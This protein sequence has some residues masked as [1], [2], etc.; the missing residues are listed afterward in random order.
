[1]HGP[2]GG[3]EIIIIRKGRSWG[4]SETFVKKNFMSLG[5]SAEEILKE[6]NTAIQQDRQRLKEAKKQQKNAES[7]ARKKEKATQEMKDLR[8]R[9]ERAKARIDQLLSNVENESELRELQQRVRNYRKDYENLKTVVAALEKQR[10]QKES[11]IQREQSQAAKLRASLAAKESK[12]NTVEVRLNN[13]K[14]LDELKEQEAELQRQNEE[15]EAV[16]QDNDA[17]PSNRK[18]AR[19]TV[20]G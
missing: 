19:E 4:I 5:K 17:S 8:I 18:A 9:T 3:K 13:T 16:V 10:K 20:A 14:T 7:I 1:M 11:T 6:D 2:R 12:R 15:D